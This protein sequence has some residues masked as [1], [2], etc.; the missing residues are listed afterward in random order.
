MR[1]SPSDPTPKGY[2][3]AL[4]DQLGFGKN[5]EPSAARTLAVFADVRIKSLMLEM[6]R[7]KLKSDAVFS[8]LINEQTEFNYT[9]GAG[10]KDA[11]GEVHVPCTIYFKVP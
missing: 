9:L 5:I 11:A 10:F 7:S 2:Q 1:F 3:L 6:V 4:T 8:R